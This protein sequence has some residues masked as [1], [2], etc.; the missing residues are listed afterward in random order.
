MRIVVAASQDSER[1][2]TTAP[3]ESVADVAPNVNG[4]LSQEIAELRQKG[5]K[6]DD[7]NDPATDNAQPSAPATQTIG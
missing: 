6:V 1:E 4:G 7:N 5:I 3:R 2:W